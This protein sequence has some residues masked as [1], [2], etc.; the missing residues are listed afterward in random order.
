MALTKMAALSYGRSPQGR[1]VRATRIR[2]A[3]ALDCGGLKPA[4]ID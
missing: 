2:V 4:W 1:V 3:P